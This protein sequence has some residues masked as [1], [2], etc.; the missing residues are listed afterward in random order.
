MAHLGM[1]KNGKDGV[2]D[3]L[4]WQLLLHGLDFLARWYKPGTW[5]HTHH[6]RTFATLRFLIMNLVQESKGDSLHT[7]FNIR[8]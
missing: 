2:L 1:H 3:Y 8:V 7:T 5:Y 6:G 4:L